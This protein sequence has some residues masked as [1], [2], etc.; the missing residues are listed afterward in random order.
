MHFLPS[1][2]EIPLRQQL[3]NYTPKNSRNL[4]PDAIPTEQLPKSSSCIEKTKEINA[5]S[6]RASVRRRKSTITEL[7]NQPEENNNQSLEDTNSHTM[8]STNN[9]LENNMNAINVECCSH[10]DEMFRMKTEL[11]SLN[12]KIKS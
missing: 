11:I 10:V 2:F 3:L 7:L 12:L 5:R 8:S 4:K 6:I 1:C 9:D